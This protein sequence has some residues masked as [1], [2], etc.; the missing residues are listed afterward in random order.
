MT[1]QVA[2]ETGCPVAHFDHHDPELVRDPW[3]TYSELRDNGPV[4]W[5]DA[6]GGYWAVAGYDEVFTAARDDETFCSRAGVSIPPEQ[7]ATV[8]PI[9]CDPP[10]LKEYRAILNPLFSPGVSKAREGEIRTLAIEC[11]EAIADSGHCDLVADIATPVPSIMTMRLLGI[12]QDR[13]RD[14]MHWYHDNSTR[15]M[16]MTRE[17]KKQH[18]REFLVFRAEIEQVIAA[19]RS[20]PTDDIITTLVQARPNDRPLTDREIIDTVS[21]VL[22]GGLDTTATA[23]I[24]ALLYLDEHRDGRERYIHDDRALELLLEELLR[25]ES[26]VHAL[27]RRATRDVELGGAQ[28][29]KDDW[30][31]LLWA[32]ANRDTSAFDT[33]DTVV[34]ERKPNRHMAFGVGQHRCLGSNLARVQTRVVVQETLRR[35]PDYRVVR[36]E[37]E[38]SAT[39][40]VVRGFLRAPAT[41]SPAGAKP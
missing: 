28:I 23:I 37:V 31:L 26:P 18:G 36:E 15:F 27:A 33:P 38:R 40:S 14:Y 16:L 5:T 19:R 32:S 3:T 29:R 9:T 4:V 22:A 10:E 34:E 39:M 21:L 35:L 17:E 12:P 41:F 25:Y 24:N 6:H 2:R 8:I 13:W 20:E 7:A 30:L 1:E 11:I